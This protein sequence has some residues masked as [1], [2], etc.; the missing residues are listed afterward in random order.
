MKLEKRTTNKRLKRGDILVS[1]S[2]PVRV[3]LG[4]GRGYYAYT[5]LF[6]Y[7]GSDPD[8]MH[9]WYVV[10]EYTEADLNWLMERETVLMIS[11]G[12]PVPAEWKLEVG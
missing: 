9:R 7:P 11:E 12:Q 5:Y 3:I 6:P 2:G 8:L 4:R 10:T 1:E